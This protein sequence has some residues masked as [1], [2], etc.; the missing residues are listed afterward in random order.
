ME[1]MA[2]ESRLFFIIS[3]SSL[4]G[5][6]RQITNAC[7]SVKSLDTTTPSHASGSCLNLLPSCPQ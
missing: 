6:Q 3:A 4:V 5:R 7:Q 1:Q 2:C